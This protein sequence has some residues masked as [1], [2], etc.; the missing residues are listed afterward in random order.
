MYVRDAIHPPLSTNPAQI[1]NAVSAGYDKLLEFFDELNSHLAQLKCLNTYTTSIPTIPELRAVLV[2]I[3]VVVL[4]LCAIWAKYLQTSRIG[5]DWYSS[6]SKDAGVLM[7]PSDGD[8]EDA[9]RRL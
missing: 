3:F 2:E 4:E 7:N 5:I 9:W 6:C 8:E 1:A